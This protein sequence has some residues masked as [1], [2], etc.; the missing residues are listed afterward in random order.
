MKKDKGKIIP[1]LMGWNCRY[2]CEVLILN[3][4]G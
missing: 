2:L 4:D 3:T 1:K